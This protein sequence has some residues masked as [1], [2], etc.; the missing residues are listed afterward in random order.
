MLAAQHGRRP[1]IQMGGV[2]LGF[3]SSRLRSQEGTAIQMGGILPYKLE[4]YCSTF[5]ETSRGWWGSPEA[6][7]IKASQP[8]FP[9]FRVRIFRVFRA[10]ALWSLLRP[11]VFVG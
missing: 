5:S 4:V 1:A 6:S 3:L 8:H 11:P 7:H 2:L 10:L 9:H